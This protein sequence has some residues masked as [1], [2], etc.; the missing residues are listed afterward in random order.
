MS[1]TKVFGL[2]A[3]PIPQTHQRLRQAHLLWHQASDN[4]QNVDLLLTNVDRLIQELRNITFILQSQ[5]S[6]FRFRRVVYRERYVNSRSAI[7]AGRRL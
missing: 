3:C 5:K 6:T 7:Q 4:Y 2:E 1:A